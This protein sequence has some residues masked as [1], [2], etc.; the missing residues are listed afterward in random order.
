MEPNHERLLMI[1]IYKN[2]RQLQLKYQN[3]KFELNRSTP[4]SITIIN[5]TELF[6]ENVWE[7]MIQ[8]EMNCDS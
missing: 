6:S 2:I 7:I 5:Q 1:G 8:V 4:V 3:R